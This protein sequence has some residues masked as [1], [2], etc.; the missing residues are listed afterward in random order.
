[1]AK[2]SKRTSPKTGPPRSD[3]A[4]RR[5]AARKEPGSRY[6]A[7]RREIAE[8]AAIEFK[9]RGF[10][11][12]TLSHV[13]EAMGVDRASLY[14]YVSNKEELFEELVSEVV[15]VNLA[16][17]VAIRDGDGSAPEKLRGLIEGL[18]ASYAEHFPVLYILIQE[19]LA[20]VAPE[21][22][23]WAESMKEI[24]RAYEAVVIE[25]I[26]AGQAD[27]TLT[28]TAPPRLLAYGIIGM[29]GWT[30]RWFNPQR[31]LLGADE[32]G[33]AFADTLLN[34]LA[35]GPP[36]RGSGAQAKPKAPAKGKGRSKAGGKAKAKAKATGTAKKAGRGA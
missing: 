30:N 32:I 13:A 23:E 2:A 20:H 22:S 9:K 34:G 3:F 1:M 17:A 29:V 28:A 36:P 12:T 33:R 15:K 6:T 26:E 5:S 18:M 31:S 27:G 11:G 7:R 10:R 14:Y 24:N 35:V 21:R 4:R 8:A 16:H 25:I 19:N